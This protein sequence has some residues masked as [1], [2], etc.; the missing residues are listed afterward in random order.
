MPA[1]LEGWQDLTIADICDEIYD[2]PHATPKKLDEGPIFLSISSLVNGRLVLSESAHLSEKDFVKWTRRITPQK[3]DL[4]FSYETRLGEAALIPA[5]LRCCLGRR[6]GLI[7]PYREMVDPQ[8]FLYYFLSPIL[9]NEIRKYTTA[10]STVQRLAL[11]DVR[12]FRILLP[13]LPEQRAIASILGALDDKI[14]LNRRMNATLESLA[15]A[16]FKSWFVDFDPVH[17]NAIRQNAG[18]INAGQMPASSQALATH[19]PEVLDL[20][21]STFQD[22]ELGPIPE[23]WEVAELGEFCDVKRGSSPRP[24]ND[25]LGGTVPWVKIADATAS[26]NPFIYETKQFIKEEG[27]SKSIPLGVGDLI[28]SNSATCGVPKFLAL[29]GCIHD[30]WL[31]FPGLNRITKE[32]LFF[33]LG[34]LADYLIQIADG[35]VQKNLNTKLVASQRV[36]VPSEKVLE[37]FTEQ[38]QVI[39]DQLYELGIETRRIAALRDSLLPQLLSGELAVP[40]ALTR[41]EEALA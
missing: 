12:K 31:F 30:G 8:Y 40:V 20:F 1:L 6:M 41:A 34:D 19:A 18:K 25:F 11:A 36:L 17:A 14:E 24:I 23:G 10:G 35:T 28:L 15:R 33:V 4:V 22:S 2:G 9:Q 29:D 38:S 5:G 16:I 32:Y 13:P 37:A 39:F 7:R 27:V 26:T 21:P 3:D